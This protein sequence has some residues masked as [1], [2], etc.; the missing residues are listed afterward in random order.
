M[1]VYIWTDSWVPTNWLLWYRPLQSDLNDE[2]WNWKNGSWY[3]WTWNFGTVWGK[4]WAIVTRSGEV[5]TQHIVT[6]LNYAWPALTMC[7]WIYYNTLLTSGRR[8]WLL[9]NCPSNNNSWPIFAIAP[10]PAQSNHWSI[11]IPNNTYSSTSSATTWTW[12]FICWVVSSSWVKIYLNASE[13]YST[14]TWNTGTWW[15]IWRLWCWQ[16]GWLQTTDWWWVDWYIRHCAVYN[17][18]LTTTEIS[19]FYTNTSN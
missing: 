13:I 9:T 7:W 2:S 4:T 19:A 14:S 5:T 1:N 17:R 16:L 12:H 15:S 11:G 18:V 3:S 6:T 8:P 10:R